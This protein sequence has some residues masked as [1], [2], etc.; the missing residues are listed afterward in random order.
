MF[1]DNMRQ[2]IWLLC[3][4]VQIKKSEADVFVDVESLDETEVVNAKIAINNFVALEEDDSTS[5][6]VRNAA[7]QLIGEL[8]RLNPEI[9][10]LLTEI[11]GAFMQ[12]KP[13]NVGGDVYPLSLMSPDYQKFYYESSNPMHAVL[14]Q[15]TALFLFGRYAP[16]IKESL[17]APEVILSE[18]F[19]NYALPAIKLA[20]TSLG[21]YE[22]LFKYRGL[23]TT[24]QILEELTEYEHF[25]SLSQEVLMEV[26]NILINVKSNLA[27][28]LAAC[29][30]LACCSKVLQK[31]S[32]KDKLQNFAVALMQ[33]LIKS[34]SDTCV[35]VL[36]AMCGLCKNPYMEQI[37]EA[38]EQM[39]ERSLKTFIDNH[40]EFEVSEEIM[41]LAASVLSHKG[42][43]IYLKVIPTIRKFV[44]MTIGSKKLAELDSGIIQRAL[45]M[46]SLM[47]EKVFKEGKGIDGP[48]VLEI[49]SIMNIIIRTILTTDDTSFIISAFGAI[50]SYLAY[51][52][53]TLTEQY[54]FV[55]QELLEC[56][57]SCSNQYLSL[58][59][60]LTLSYTLNSDIS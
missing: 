9:I 28:K 41:R 53:N 26:Y 45:D 51:A 58:L 35:L 23:C 21:K 16:E 10:S 52:F 20:G 7:I 12:N 1:A 36:R 38:V 37:P 42:A 11:I 17:T 39:F 14:K 18:V 6:S 54:S 5:S 43:S 47:I 49:Q 32:E 19:R 34:S 13:Q 29:K 4:Y 2:F 55:L 48:G 40:G 59:R 46:F 56:V 50:R 8:I 57:T 15:E 31:V 27:V 33:V 44:G 60:A 24:V 22:N 25:E 30:V 3:T